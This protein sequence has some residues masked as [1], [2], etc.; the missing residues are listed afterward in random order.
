MRF[1]YAHLPYGVGRN[2]TSDPPVRRRVL[3]LLSYTPERITYAS[4]MNPIRPTVV[5]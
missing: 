2:R 5:D 1:Q 4:M 3:Y